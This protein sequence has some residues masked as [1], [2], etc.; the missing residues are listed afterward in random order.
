MGRERPMPDPVAAPELGRRQAWAERRLALEQRHERT[1][2]YGGMNPL[3]WYATAL[4]VKLLKWGLLLTGLYRRGRRNAEW[5]V[6]REI[7]LYFET[8]PEAF[9]GFTILHLSDPHLDAM[10]GLEQRVLETIDGRGVD[11]C[12]LTGDYRK[13]FHG[14]CDAAMKGMASL[15]GGIR[16]GHGILGVLGNHDGCQMLAPLEALG[17]RML[18]NESHMLEKDGQRLQ[19][20]GTDDVHYYY[21]E[22]ALEALDPARN[23]FTIGLVHSPELVEEAA[24][25]GV[26]LYLCGHSHAGQVC[27]PGGRPLA[28]QL[29]RGRQYYKGLWRHGAMRGFTHAGVGTSCLPVRFNTR[30]EVVLLRLRRG[31]EPKRPFLH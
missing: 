17:I 20:L 16:H 28:T 21:T 12:V 5:L 27:L 8:L 14:P 24:R 4:L 1:K 23:H 25:A 13:N 7:D 6:F 30:G 11:V 22:A 18:V 10:P 15:V 29:K 3:E 19:I 26:D 9:D 31:T 2:T